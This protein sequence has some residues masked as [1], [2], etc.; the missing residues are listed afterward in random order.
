MVMTRDE[1]IHLAANL[2]HRGKRLAPDRFPQPSR[3]TVEDWALALSSL[4][5]TMPREIWPEVI[6]VWASELVGDRMITIRELK[7]AAYITRDRWENDPQKREI[8]NRLREERTAERDRQLAA[9][10]FGQLRGYSS[11]QIE[12]PRAPSQDTKRK[13]DEVLR[14]IGRTVKETK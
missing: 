10:T 12:E 5:D 4:F 1:K 7:Q 14:S 6:V 11:R 9:G 3:E 8:L 13:I 2:L